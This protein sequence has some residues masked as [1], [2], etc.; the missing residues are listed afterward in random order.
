MAIIRKCKRWK[1]VNHMLVKRLEEKCIT[2]PKLAK[3]VG[4]TERQVQRFTER[5]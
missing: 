3:M 4:I 2:I 5:R 1:V